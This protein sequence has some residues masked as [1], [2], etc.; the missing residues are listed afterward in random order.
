MYHEGFLEPK[1]EA[2]LGFSI[3]LIILQETYQPVSRFM[4]FQ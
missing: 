3:I 1:F 4:P 2:T